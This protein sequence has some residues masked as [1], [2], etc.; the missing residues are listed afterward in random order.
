[1]LS[2]IT[3]SSAD[4][5][6][7]QMDTTTGFLD[8]YV[9]SGRPCEVLSLFGY[10]QGGATAY[11]MLFDST[12]F[13]QKSITNTNNATG[14]ITSASHGLVTGDHV[15]LTDITGLTTGWVNKGNTSTF[16]L[17]ASF[18]DAVSSTNVL[19]PTSNGDTGTVE[20]MPKHTLAIGAA[21][22]FSFIIPATGFGFGRGLVVA[23]SSTPALFTPST[24]K[25]ITLLGTLK[26]Y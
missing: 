25:D 11:V 20:I 10:H 18:D 6:A 1:M 24:T 7:S 26:A 23:L 4:S 5:A 15:A 13:P 2:Q 19:L 21:D 3:F 16:K 17:Y 12:F 14:A 8:Y 22:N 9:V